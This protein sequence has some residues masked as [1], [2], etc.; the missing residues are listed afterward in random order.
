M[1]TIT[2]VIVD[3]D[4]TVRKAEI[5]NDLS[6]FQA[7]VGGYIEP[8]SGSFA[9]V[10]VNEEGLIM[11]LP[12]NP[13]ASLFAMQF[14]NLYGVRLFG[15]ALIVGPPDGD[16]SDTHVRPSVVDYYNLED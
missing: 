16:G 13:T 15:T 9:T 12:F 5:E 11:G 1:A 6:A 3:P 8:V 10:Y 7:V 2:A 4:G 14:L